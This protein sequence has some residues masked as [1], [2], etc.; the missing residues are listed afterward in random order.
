M[1]TVDVLVVLVFNVVVHF[2]V[3]DVVELLVVVVVF[4]VELDFVVVGVVVHFEVVVVVWRV[5]VFLANWIQ[6]HTDVGL[7]VVLVVVVVVVL[8]VVGY[9]KS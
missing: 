7:L 1:L 5:S 9:A 6:Q 3:V 2:V 4:V 8:V